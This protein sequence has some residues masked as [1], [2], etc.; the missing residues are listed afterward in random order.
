MLKLSADAKS[1]LRSIASYTKKI[2]GEK[3]WDAYLQELESCFKELSAFPKLGEMFD[4]VRMRYRKYPAGKHMI[5]YR[6]LSNGDF[7]VSRILHQSE[8][9]TL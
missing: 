9:I 1:D 7:E 3:Q 4:G 6:S 5:Y 2:W 8:D